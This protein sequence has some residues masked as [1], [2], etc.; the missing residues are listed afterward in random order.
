MLKLHI[1]LELH[2]Y[3]TSKNNINNIWFLLHNKLHKYKLCNMTKNRNSGVHL[4]DDIVV[5]IIPLKFYLELII[6][7][8]I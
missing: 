2:F 3:K 7:A 8:Y 1:C 4:L 5:I 6:H